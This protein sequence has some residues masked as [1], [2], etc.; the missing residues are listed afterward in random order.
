MIELKIGSHV[1]VDKVFLGNN[2]ENMVKPYLLE[3]Y[4]KKVNQDNGNIVEDD[5]PNAVQ[6]SSLDLTDESEF[7]DFMEGVAMKLLPTIKFDDTEK[8][9]PAPYTDYS[10]Y[11]GSF[12]CGGNVGSVAIPG[13]EIFTV[14]RGLNIFDKFVGGSNKAYVAQ[15]T[16]N[17]AYQGGVIGSKDERTSYVDAFGNIKNRIEIN[18]QRLNIIPKRWNDAKTALEWNTHKWGYVA[19]EDGTELT[20]GEVYYTSAVGDGKF[21]AN[22]EEKADADHHY[23]E[24]GFYEVPTDG[25]LDRTLRLMGGNV[26]GGCYESGH[27]N[28]NVVININ[29]NVM[30]KDEIFGAGNSGVDLEKGQRDDVMAVAMSVFGGGYGED[31]EIWGSTTVNHNKG[32]AFQIFGGGEQ[33]VVGKKVDVKDEHGLVVD[34]VYE[35]NPAYSTTVNLSGTTPIYSS[36]GKN[37]ELAEVE[38]IYGGGNEGNICGNTL[39]NLGNGRIYDAFGGSSD[40]DIFGHTEVYIGR[41]PNGSSYKDG[42]PWIKDI[43]YGGNDFGGNIEGQYEDGYN[44]QARLRDFAKDKTQIHGYKESPDP[45]VVAV[46]DILKSSSYV[47]YLQGRVDTIF[48]GGYGCY[49]YSDIGYYGVGG[50][51]PTQENAYVNVRPKD[52]S[53]NFINCVFGGGTGYPGNRKNDAA[54]SSSYVLIDIPDGTENFSTMQVFGSGCYNGMGMN[55]PVPANAVD[56]PGESGTEEDKKK[57]Q[58]YLAYQDYL[59]TPDKYSSVIDLLRGNIQ[60]AFGGS[61]QQGFT[62]RTVVN[63][64][65]E[66]SIKIK[67]IFGGAYGTQI[68]PPCDVYETNVNYRNTSE[69]ALASAIYGGNNNERRSLYTHVNVSSPIWSNKDKGYLA[70][71]YGAGRGID[72]W[73]EYTEV[74]LE[75]GAKVYEVYGGGEMGHVLSSESVQQ[76]MQMYKDNLSPQISKQDPFW[77]SGDK[78]TESAGKI[79]PKPEYVARWKSDWEDAWTIGEGDN[80]YYTPNADYSNYFSNGVTN[81]TNSKMVRTAEMDDRDYTGYSADEKS[82]RINKYNT[83]VIINEGAT[84]VN[85]AYGGGLGDTEE[86]RSGD[87]YGAT[88]IAP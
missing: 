57:Y 12:Y 55:A 18:L 60:N 11:V 61:Y 26:Y 35:Y 27:V 13:S 80:A 25:T 42:F 23:W 43:V 5:A 50:A 59:K 66:S 28:G 69:K 34:H 30:K 40:A 37:T 75:K 14:S 45:D 67:S 62:R 39:V 84:V 29:E 49:D 68:L 48:G 33:G 19:V 52:H 58:K 56:D 78:W 31:T 71:V 53:Q 38:Y 21:T 47:E 88:Y 17:A 74:N 64:P 87:V 82:K 41:Q 79:T 54:Q 81:L 73:S 4:A 10:S 51:M 76:Y 8:G 9:D 6:Y 83:N 65:A 63:V 86:E 3:L 1:I 77:N 70:T 2:G 72:T 85:Y 20:A 32:Y 22:G 46:P 7:A 44:F 16:Y 36:D 15:G 24:Q